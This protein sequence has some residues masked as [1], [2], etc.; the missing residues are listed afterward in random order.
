[1]MPESLTHICFVTELHTYG[2]AV[3]PKIKRYCGA[4]TAHRKIGEPHET[5]GGSGVDVAGKYG[6]RHIRNIWHDSAAVSSRAGHSSLCAKASIDNCYDRSTFVELQYS[7]VH[8]KTTMYCIGRGARET[9]A[10][11]LFTWKHKTTFEKNTKIENNT[12]ACC[13]CKVLLSY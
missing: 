1:M 5:G 13:D 9:T 2:G 12:I 4:E 11:S 7:I 8:N 3:E 10:C 6:R